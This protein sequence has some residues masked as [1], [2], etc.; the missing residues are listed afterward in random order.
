MNVITSGQNDVNIFRNFTTNSVNT[1]TVKN[2]LFYV[3]NNNNN[4][5]TSQKRTTSSSSSSSYS[6]S[7]SSASG[8]IEQIQFSQND[9][10]SIG[11]VHLILGPMF[12]GK[13]T[14]LLKRVQE[15]ERAGANVLLIKSD[16]DTRYAKDKVVTHDGV[17]RECFPVKSLDVEVVKEAVGVERWEEAD[18]VA[19][20]EAQFLTNLY[21]FCRV[22]ADED[23]KIVLVAGLNGDFKR[24][25]FGE[26]QETLPL[27]DSVT[28]LTAKCKCGRAALFSKRV[29]SVQGQELVGGADKYLP[30]CR[31]CYLI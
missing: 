11:S 23:D 16:K 4:N 29:V 24:E 27:C 3:A 31:R 13:T 22:V 20:D 5:N 2:I 26:V 1:K 18:C 7:A 21:E 17:S 15:L 12:A 6:A 28:K 9:K 10:T 30:A 25:P 19:I 8:T 14:A